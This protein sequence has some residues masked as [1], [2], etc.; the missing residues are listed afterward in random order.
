MMSVVLSTPIF[1]EEEAVIR[2]VKPILRDG[3]YTP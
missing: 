1:P 3:K 2:E